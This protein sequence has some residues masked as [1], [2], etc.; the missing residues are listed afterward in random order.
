MKELI[1]QVAENIRKYRFPTYDEKELQ[2]LMHET[3]LKSLG[4][5]REY[6]LDSKN[7]V[8]F[9]HAGYGLALEVKIKGSAPAIHRQ[10]ARY[11][12]FDEVKAL[13][14]ASAKATGWPT[15]ING[16]PSYFIG[17]GQSWL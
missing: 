17:L 16:K 11:M 4:F 5:Q 1:S 8:D 6:R 10:C 3:F 14:L 2:D 13:C 9:F 7:V 15:E 12:K